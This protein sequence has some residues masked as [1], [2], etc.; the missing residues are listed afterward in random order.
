MNDTTKRW[1][2]ALQHFLT[3]SESDNARGIPL[4]MPEYR[5]DIC[6]AIAWESGAYFLDFRAEV[7]KEHGM[8]AH[9][10]SLNKLDQVLTMRAIE[11][12]VVAFNV[13]SLLAAKDDQVRREW[14]HRFCEK[15]FDHRVLLPL[16][17]FQ[18]DIPDMELCLDLRE[19][20]FEPQS[21]ISRLA[22]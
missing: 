18:D 20:L 11:G 12:D 10:I 21:L 4:L 15:Q 5:P 9:D 16:A 14:L 2:D 22:M 1:R 3:S 13:E 8:L 19:Y 7:M 6:R 17:I